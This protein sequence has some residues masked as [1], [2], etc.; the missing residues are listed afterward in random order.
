MVPDSPVVVSSDSDHE[1][2]NHGSRPSSPSDL[3]NSD[4]EDSPRA[5]RITRSQAAQ[6]ASGA[7]GCVGCCYF[8]LFTGPMKMSLSASPKKGAG[9]PTKVQCL[10]LFYLHLSVLNF[11]RF[12]TSRSRAPLRSVHPRR[13][14]VWLSLVFCFVCGCVSDRYLI[15]LQKSSE[16]PKKGAASPSK[17]SCCLVL[18]VRVVCVPERSMLLSLQKPSTPAKVRVGVCVYV[19]VRVCVRAL[20]LQKRRRS[21]YEVGD[22]VGGDAVSSAHEFM[23]F[24]KKNGDIIEV[25]RGTIV[26]IIGALGGHS[27]ID[28]VVVR[29]E[30]YGGKRREFRFQAFRTTGAERLIWYSINHCALLFHVRRY[31]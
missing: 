21:S 1:S 18:R 25:R 16:S 27:N 13:F 15:C 23:R 9:S 22:R 12:V 3:C 17:V 2:S 26:R 6:L 30:I 10:F 14:C 11:V 31:V 7:R 8:G 4:D 24:T 5:P 19:C 20:V 28:W 29:M